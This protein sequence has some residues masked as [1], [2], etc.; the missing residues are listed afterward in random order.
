[1]GD[2]NQKAVLDVEELLEK[3]R[4]MQERVEY[5]QAARQSTQETL[6]L[7]ED[8]KREQV[9]YTFKQVPGTLYSSLQ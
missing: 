6:E 2:I 7:L 8:K 1:M 9:A 5:L 4:E 3:E